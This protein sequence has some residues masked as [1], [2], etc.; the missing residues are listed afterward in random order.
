MTK[1]ST[2]LY[3]LHKNQNSDEGEPEGFFLHEAVM[4]AGHPVRQYLESK[5]KPVPEY[6][7]QKV[8]NG[9]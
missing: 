3:Y 7:V 1:V 9:I 8:L 5:R 6:V 2:L 4:P